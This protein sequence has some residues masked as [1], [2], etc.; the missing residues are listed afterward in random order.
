MGE[1]KVLCYYAVVLRFFGVIEVIFLQGLVNCQVVSIKKKKQPYS[2]GMQTL[3]WDT[4]SSLIDDKVARSNHGEMVLTTLVLINCLSVKKIEYLTN[5][6][7]NITG[8]WTN[9]SIGWSTDCANE[10]KHEYS[11]NGHQTWHFADIH[12]EEFLT[13]QRIVSF[14]RHCVLFLHFF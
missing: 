1:Q 11:R 4:T 7:K 9:E 13:S 10:A 14:C 8:C 12:F 6:T 3:F 5:W 2:R